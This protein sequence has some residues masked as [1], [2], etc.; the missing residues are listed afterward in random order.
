MDVCMF[1]YI[2][3]YVYICAP[4]FVRQLCTV[5]H[6]FSD[7]LV[8]WFID[9]Y[10]NSAIDRFHDSSH[11][12][13][14]TSESPPS[15]QDTQR[16]CGTWNHAVSRPFHVLSVAPNFGSGYKIWNRLAS[17]IWLVAWG[18]PGSLKLQGKPATFFFF[19]TLEPRVEWYQSLCALNTS[20]PRNHCTFL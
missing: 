19:V 16:M 10:I 13:S 7:S 2:R 1:T 3:V 17:V 6:W 4:Q 9:Q 11:Q 8:H 12:V 14:R 20:P 18:G 15:F 5:I